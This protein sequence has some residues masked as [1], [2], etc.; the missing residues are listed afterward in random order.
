[1]VNDKSNLDLLCFLPFSHFTENKTMLC[2][3]FIALAGN[4]NLFIYY[5]LILLKYLN[6]YNQA[7]QQHS[8]R[9]DPNNFLGD[10]FD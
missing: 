4:C 8:T 3:I 1:M 5:L 9:D 7:A 2:R 10:I 6:D